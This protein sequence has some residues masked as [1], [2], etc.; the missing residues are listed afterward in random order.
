MASSNQSIQSHQNNGEKP[1]QSNQNKFSFKDLIVWQKSI[2]F[3][4]EIIDL[5]E[6]LNTTRN[7]YRLV[8]QLEAAATSISMNIAEGKGR[9]SKKEFAHFLMIARGSL[10]ET[11]TLIEIFKLRSWI[12]TEKFEQLESEANEIAIKINALYNSIKL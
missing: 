12:S 10:Y 11:I 5:T 4:N 3:A 8:E 6:S 1:S 2:E 7:H 9:F